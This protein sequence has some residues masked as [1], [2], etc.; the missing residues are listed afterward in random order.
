MVRRLVFVNANLFDSTTGATRPDATV[1]VEGESVT[2]VSFGRHP[3][4]DDNDQDRDAGVYDLA[5][6]TL[7][8][9]LIDAHVHVTATVADF[10][11]LSYMPPSLVTAQAKDI[12]EAMLRRGFTTV[13]DAAGADF[14]LAE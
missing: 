2:R 6:R 12:L 14:G 8:P 5:G 4:P 7:M 3:I 11:E 13:R 1:V 10:L 9:G